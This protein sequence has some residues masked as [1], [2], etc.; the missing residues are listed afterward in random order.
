LENDSEIAALKA[1]P[2]AVKDTQDMQDVMLRRAGNYGPT[3]REMLLA[4]KQQLDLMQA[5]TVGMLNP[6]L[7][8]AAAW[9]TEKAR[10]TMNVAPPWKLYT[11]YLI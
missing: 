5:Q 11:P 3:P 6:L 8:L 9:Q 7:G 1:H 4:Q 2:Q 10:A